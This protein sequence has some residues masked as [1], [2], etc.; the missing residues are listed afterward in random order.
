MFDERNNI[1]TKRVGTPLLTLAHRI[2]RIKIN[3][4]NRNDELQKNQKPTG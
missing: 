2:M 3:N 1:S 4:I